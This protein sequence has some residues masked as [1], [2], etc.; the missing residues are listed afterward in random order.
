MLC[1]CILCPTISEIY[2][3]DKLLETK[4]NILVWMVSFSRFNIFW[5]IFYCMVFFCRF[6]DLKHWLAG[7][8]KWCKSFFFNLNLYHNAESG[9]LLPYVCICTYVMLIWT[10]IS[11]HI[12]IKIRYCIGLLLETVCIFIKLSMM[13][14]FQEKTMN[15]KR[16]CFNKVFKG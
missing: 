14:P 10:T 13:K 4:S 9:H 7:K 3:K 2:Y 5:P 16:H 1:K 12:Q 11:V 15:P 8:S 6:T